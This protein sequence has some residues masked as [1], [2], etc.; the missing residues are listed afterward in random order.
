VTVESG[1]GLIHV[2]GVIDAD[3]ARLMIDCGVREI[4]IP[5]VLGYHTAD[6]TPAAAAAIVAEFDRQ[7]GFFLVTYLDQADAVIALCR[8]L[9]VTKVQLHGDI[10][11]QELHKL[12]VGWPELQI[13]KSLIVRGDN[14]QALLSELEHFTPLVDTFITDTFDP[15]TGAI[16]ATGK[17][18]DWSVSAQLVKDS[19]RPVILAGGLTAGNVQ[20]A[21]RQTGAAGVDVHTGVEGTDGRKRRDL[22][23]RFVA[24]TTAGFA[25]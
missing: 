13:I 7:A 15:D 18:H 19:S 1:A 24:E 8:Q 5:L 22:L 20:R 2:A 12:R 17:P 4:G 11:V 14:L 23:E 21:I 10:S 16:G 3:E 6:L 25:A 9:H